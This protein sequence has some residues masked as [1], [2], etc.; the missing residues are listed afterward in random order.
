MFFCTWLAFFCFVT[1]FCADRSGFI[2]ATVSHAW[3][4]VQQF[5]SPSSHLDYSHSI[6]AFFHGFAHTVHKKKGEVSANLFPTFINIFGL[7]IFPESLIEQLEKET[8][9]FIPYFPVL[10]KSLQ[11]IEHHSTCIHKF[12]FQRKH[13]SCFLPLDF[14]PFNWHLNNFV[15]YF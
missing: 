1:V 13:L 5:L 14:F 9:I 4:Y 12:P 11:S 2:A 8:F 3:P 10:P 7:P 15:S 6:L